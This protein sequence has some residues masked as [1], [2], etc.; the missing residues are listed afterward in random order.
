TYALAE[1]GDFPP[2]LGAIHRK[3]RTPH[4]SILVFALLVWALAMAGTFRWNVI[5]SAVARLF[6]YG[7]VCA[8]LPVLRRRQPH[9]R[10]FRLPAGVLFAALGMA[11]SAVLVTRMGRGELWAM[12]ATFA[13]AFVN[14]LWVRR[15]RPHP[16]PEESVDR[17]PSRL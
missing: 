6:A 16:T 11:F 12:S 9:A 3:F 2:M 13:T 15:A 10:G 7:L 5:L 17:P 1:R 4:V 8:A 14:W